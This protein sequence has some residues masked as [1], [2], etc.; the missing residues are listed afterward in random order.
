MKRVLAT[1][2][3]SQSLVEVTTGTS[4]VKVRK[5]HM[6]L[7][8]PKTTEEFRNRINT[9]SICLSIAAMKQDD[10]CGAVETVH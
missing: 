2:S 7:P 1:H 6:S 3:Q 10:F 8:S 5:S 4:V 9:L